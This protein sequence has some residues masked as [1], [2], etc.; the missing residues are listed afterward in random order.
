MPL[1]SATRLWAFSH[2]PS[3][4]SINSGNTENPLTCHNCDDW[5]TDIFSLVL[6][7]Y[8]TSHVQLFT[9]I[10]FLFVT[11]SPFTY[12][13]TCP[14]N[15]AMQNYIYCAVSQPLW[16]DMKYFSYVLLYVYSFLVLSYAD[17][18]VVNCAVSYVYLLLLLT[19]LCFTVA[20]IIV[21]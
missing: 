3:G 1:S 19:V 21:Q 15:Q 2:M 7:N 5:T 18:C 16:S 9:F 17:C 13:A 12:N 10:T 4:Y 6:C 11:D 14:V 20:Y 8:Q